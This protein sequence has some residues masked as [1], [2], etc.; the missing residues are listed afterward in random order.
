VHGDP[1]RGRAGD[2]S[3]QPPV[4]RTL[5]LV[6][7]AEHERARFGALQASSAEQVQQREIAVAAVLRRSG[8]RNRRPY[9]PAVSARGSPRATL[10]RRTSWTRSTP[11]L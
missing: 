3:G 9:C 10:W 1:P 7:V 8:I 5:A 11:E 6:D 2:R 4:A